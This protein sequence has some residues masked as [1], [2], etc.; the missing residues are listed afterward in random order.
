[1]VAYD[2]VGKYVKTSVT[3][4][5]ICFAL[6]IVLGL[7]DNPDLVRTFRILCD[8]FFVTSVLLMGF[9]LFGIISTTGFFDIFG[10]SAEYAKSVFFPGLRKKRNAKD[11]AEYK[12]LRK[13]RKRAEWHNVIVG[14]IFLAISM[15][16]L[17]LEGQ[18]RL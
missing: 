3:G 1:M 13:D 5:F 10:Y 11:Y 15:V 16:F 6:V 7:F 18:A 9:G 8:S 14:A 2:R 4:A 12:S 17:V